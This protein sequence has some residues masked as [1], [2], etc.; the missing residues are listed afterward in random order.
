MPPVRVGVQVTR[1]AT[2]VKRENLGN[3]FQHHA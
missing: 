3:A 1:N 2:V